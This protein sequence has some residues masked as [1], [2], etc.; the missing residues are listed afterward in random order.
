MDF[1]KITYKFRLKLNN[2]DDKL[3]ILIFLILILENF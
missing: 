3:L 2:L 1:H